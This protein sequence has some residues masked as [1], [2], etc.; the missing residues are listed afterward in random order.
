MKY[1]VIDTFKNTQQLMSEK[2]VRDIYAKILEEIIYNWSD[3]DDKEIISGLKKEKEEVYTKDI[4]AVIEAIMED[5]KWYKISEYPI[6]KQF[7]EKTID[8]IS[9]LIGYAD[10]G[11]ISRYDEDYK[12]FFSTIDDG[13][14]LIERLEELLE[15]EAI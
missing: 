11:T 8:V 14:Y 3:C 7:I 15:S 9:D 1:L 13:N 5:D 6:N 4:K 12:C 10:D 2:E